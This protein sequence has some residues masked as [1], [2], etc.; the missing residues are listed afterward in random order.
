MVFGKRTKFYLICLLL[1][2][3]APLLLRG[4]QFG[5]D[6][7]GG[8]LIEIKLDIRPDEAFDM[9]TVV[10]VLQNRLNAYGLKDVA[11]KPW[12]GQYIVVEIAETDPEAVNQLQSLL[13]QQGKFETLFEG[14]VVL[15]GED[16]VSVI[17]DPQKGYGVRQIGGQYEW[18]VPFFLT[19]EAAQ[20]FASAIEGMCTPVPDSSSCAE[21]VY[22]FIDKPEDAVV[23]MDPL[24]H[25][26][27]SAI[28]ED[29]DSSPNTI[30]L[31]SLI[32]NSGVELV[33]ST[34]SMSNNTLER[35]R[36]KT[37][38]IAEDS[39]FSITILESYAYRVIE[40][41]QLSKFWIIDALNLEN[42]VHLTPGVTSG[43]PVTQP[44]ITGRASD[45]GEAVAELNRV[46]ILL[47]SGKLPVSVSV[48]S[49]STI[50]PT[51][52][53]GFL[54][55]SAIAGFAAIITVAGVIFIRYRK[56]KIAFPIMITLVSEIFMILGVASLIGWQLDLPSVAGIVTAVGT[57]VDDQIIIVDEVLRKEEEDRILSIA[58]KIKRAFS[59]IFMSAGTI[60]F[61]M[62][63]LLFMGLGILKGFAITT[64]IGVFVGIFI[65]RPAFAEWIDKLL[66]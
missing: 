8:T 35:I 5:M 32:E 28:P 55:Y 14:N 29:L 54:N 38:I 39:P 51:L 30:P 18:S 11:V 40:K 23:L 10:T 61:A 62:A 31:E 9:Q 49:I 63:P 52:G 48:G 60:I 44:S 17:M 16:I 50:S 22:M 25:D 26:R 15:T 43:R 45:E 19:S 2:G 36:N 6:F 1:L 21:V 12:G 24:L 65:T 66:K 33:I 42:I 27:E 4:L 20:S 34:A 47:K 56:I 37:V 59:I 57:G 41:P 53:G 58:A 46:A 3:V 13:G 64:I 7:T